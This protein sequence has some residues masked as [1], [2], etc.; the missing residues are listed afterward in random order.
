M[1]EKLGSVYNRIQRQN[2]A[3]RDTSVRRMWRRVEMTFDGGRVQTTHV[4]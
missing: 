4:T 1:S 3:Y 2:V